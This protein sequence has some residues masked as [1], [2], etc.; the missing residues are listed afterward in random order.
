M[1]YLLTVFDVEFIMDDAT[2]L[3]L[4]VIQLEK[5]LV[6]E[7]LTYSCNLQFCQG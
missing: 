7:D 4:S 6:L 2:G 3:V 5:T 1:P